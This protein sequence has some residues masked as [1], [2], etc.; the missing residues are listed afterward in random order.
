MEFSKQSPEQTN[1]CKETI[2]RTKRMLDSVST[3]EPLKSP[4]LG[5]V[6]FRPRTPRNAN[7]YAQPMQIERSFE[8]QHGQKYRG[9]NRPPIL[10]RERPTLTGELAKSI[11]SV[12]CY[13]TPLGHCTTKS[14]QDTIIQRGVH[15]I[16][17]FS[18]FSLPGKT[19]SLRK[20][21]LCPPSRMATHFNSS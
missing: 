21:S 4:P 8:S 2:L 11:W 9:I 10:Q 12:L 17:L 18:S 7:T 14:L 5:G 15:L 3:K 20:P 1:R 16:C 19:H 13:F 6:R